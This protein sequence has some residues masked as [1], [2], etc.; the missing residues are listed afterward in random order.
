MTT[1]TWTAGNTWSTATWTG[2]I[3]VAGDDVV[4]NR[5]SNQTLTYDLTGTPPSFK[6]LTISNN[7]NTLALGN[8]TL[9]VNF[10]GSTGINVGVGAITIAGGTIND[11]A[12][13]NTGTGTISG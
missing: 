4:L 9:N 13:V 5:S 10:S 6:S 12:G 1:K 7:Q 8:H 2:G 3:P 11:S